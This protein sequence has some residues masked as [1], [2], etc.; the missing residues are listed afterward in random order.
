MEQKKVNGAVWFYYDSV[1]EFLQ[2]LIK[3]EGEIFRD[4][5]G[6]RW[7]YE[8]YKFYFG[9]I[10]K[11]MCEGVACLHLFRTGITNAL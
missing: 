8:K 9:D 11:E 5:F 1:M 4:S 6:R 3:Y 7:K 2:D 10:N